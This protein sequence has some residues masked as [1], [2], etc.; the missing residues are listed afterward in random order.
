MPPSVRT[1]SGLFQHCIVPRRTTAPPIA[2]SIAWQ[3]VLAEAGDQDCAALTGHD[4]PVD[5]RE[6]EVLAQRLRAVTRELAV[7]GITPAQVAAQIAS[8]HLPM[9]AGV[10]LA[11][12]AMNRALHTLLESSGLDDPDAAIG[13]ALDKGHITTGTMTHVWIVAADPPPRDRALLQ[14]LVQNG[15][16]CTS[17]V[18]GH[19]DVLADAFDGI[20]AINVD[21]WAD[22]GIQIDTQHMHA[23]EHVTDQAAVLL[24]CLAAQ[25]DVQPND[26][27]VV[28]PD[29]TLLPV[30]IRAGAMESVHLH[31]A[32]GLCATKGRV[33]SLLVRL[34]ACIVNDDASSWGDLLRHPDVERLA[35]IDALCSWDD[36]WSTH[37]PRV[38]DALPDKAQR[39]LHDALGNVKDLIAPLLSTTPAP[40]SAWAAPIASVLQQILGTHDDGT[41]ADADV[42]STVQEHL[43]SLH[44]LPPGAMVVQASAV[45]ASL[46]AALL[47]VHQ[48]PPPHVDAIDCIGWLDAHLDDAPLCVITG[49]NEGIV[50]GAPVAEPWLPE[51][52]RHALG[53]PTTHSRA[54]RDAWLLHAIL[55]SGRQVE[56]VLARRGM[57]G[58]PL[59]PSRLLLGC[60]G[61]PLAERTLRLLGRSCSEPTLDDRQPPISDECGFEL[62]P[63]PQGTPDIQ[64]ISVTGFGTF[65]RSPY[66]F[67]LQRDR[68]VASSS[69]EYRQDLDPM[70]FGVFVHAA[71]DRWGRMELD[72]P[73][74]TTDVGRIQQELLGALDHIA[75]EQFGQ[76]PMPGVRLQK[77]IA[78][79]RLR[80]FAH[81]QAAH[82]NAGWQV[83]HVERSFSAGGRGDRAPLLPHANGLFI[84]G[85]I[86]RVDHHPDLG[87]MAI[88]YKTAATPIDPEKAHRKRDGSWINLQLPLYAFLLQSVGLDVEGSHLGYVYLSPSEEKSGFSMASW[89]AA[90]LTSAQDEAQRIVGIVQRGELIDLAMQEVA[91]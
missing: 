10:W 72:R 58:D 27:S 18:H 11:I 3:Q 35:P 49:L 63:M 77:E 33:G 89:N 53:L 50:P 7:T 42:M 45:L 43:Q 1:P 23:C 5:E 32:E 85:R 38:L 55:H 82:A 39:S 22:H 91:L 76:H 83:A 90:D 61:E 36:A 37:L 24:E 74:P 71:L 60:T 19:E 54:A 57:E 25:G 2:L 86:D 16:Q 48:V 46:V 12:D 66:S 20:G 59:L 68:R 78:A 26:V 8:D 29:S 14:A 34:H 51:G 30:L 80:H 41:V 87:W 70:G 84:T 44:E 28:V 73:G 81:H 75:S 9:K 40:V 79:H 65:L 47:E 15:V 62:K 69:V 13:A 21:Y 31:A 67:L 4:D 64:S 17:V 6:R 88:D 56:L 52:L